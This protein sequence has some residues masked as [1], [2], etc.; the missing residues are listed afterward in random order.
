MQ[1]T[2]LADFV[3]NKKRELHHVKTEKSNEHS[4]F[5]N[6]FCSSLAGPKLNAIRPEN[7]S[8]KLRE[9]QTLLSPTG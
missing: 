6:C 4:L 7:L 3:L 8:E 2:T 5:S 9:K 1:A